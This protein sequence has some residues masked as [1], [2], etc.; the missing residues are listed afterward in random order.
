MQLSYYQ[1]VKVVHL[2]AQLGYVENIKW[3]GGR[4]MREG[5][6]NIALVIWCAR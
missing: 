5:Q 3:K 4:M 2:L 1:L 6:K